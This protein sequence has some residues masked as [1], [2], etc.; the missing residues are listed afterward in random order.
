MRKITRRE[1]DA[2]VRA[3]LAKKAA[4][5]AAG[6]DVERTWKTACRT[7]TLGRARDVLR[8]MAG[9]RERCMF[10]EDSR[11]TD[12]DHYWPK[13]RYPEKAFLWVNFVLSCAGCNRQKGEQF[14]LDANGN[15]LLINP[16]E[17]EPWTML[18]FDPVTGNITARWDPQT[19][20]PD[21]RGAATVDPRILPL[22]IQGVTEGRKRTARRLARSVQA[23]LRLSNDPTTAREAE[24]ELLAAVL[25][26]EEY[27]LPE[28]FFLYDGAATEPFVSLQQRYPEVWEKVQDVVRLELVN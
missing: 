15:P 13:L 1:L 11:G 21:P 18:F 23:F 2:G 28:W 10:C 17:D 12:I 24:D 22:N 5:I 26:N 20:Q 27:G 19:D 7:K 9:G 3:Y 6:A 14:P 4:L 8:A 16:T 25:D